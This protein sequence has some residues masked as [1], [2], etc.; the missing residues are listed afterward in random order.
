VWKIIVSTLLIVL[1]TTATA[2]STDKLMIDLNALQ[3]PNWTEQER[4]NATVITDFVQNLMN[5][6]N[7]D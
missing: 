6:H 1:S 4:A 7:F 5:N 3:K 2:Q